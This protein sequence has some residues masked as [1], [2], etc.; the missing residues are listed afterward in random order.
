MKVTTWAIVTAC[1]LCAL[2]SPRV[3]AELTPARGLVDPRV[4]TACTRSHTSTD[5]STID[6]V[7]EMP[8]QLSSACSSRRARNLRRLSV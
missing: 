8:A 5:I 4:L 6:S 2:T 1:A 7:G 3:Y